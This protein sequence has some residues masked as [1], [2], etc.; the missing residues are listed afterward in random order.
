LPLE[1]QSLV[2]R[3]RRRAEIRLTNTER[4]SVQEGRPD[5]T[6]ALLNE[7][8]DALSS[9]RAEVLEAIE[10]FAEFQRVAVEQAQ[11]LRGDFWLALHDGSGHLAKITYDHLDALLALKTRLANVSSTKIGDVE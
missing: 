2:F 5:R 9:L 10:P 7:A 1:Q 3:L 4:K 8:A 6:A 11:S